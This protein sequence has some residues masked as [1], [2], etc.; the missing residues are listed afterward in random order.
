L[1]EALAEALTPRY[2]LM[3]LWLRQG[4]PCEVLAVD[5]LGVLD[6]F[7][8]DNPVLIGEEVGGV[9][10][11]LV[12]RWHPGRIRKLALVNPPD[13]VATVD[14]LDTCSLRWDDT[15]IEQIEQFLRR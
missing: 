10:A 3:S 15:T 9:A 6:Q 4:L 8:F 2:R 13:E 1:I 7:G 12:A 11:L 14:G 5:L